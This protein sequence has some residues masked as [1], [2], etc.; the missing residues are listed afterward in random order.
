MFTVI[1]II[2]FNTIFIHKKRFRG[3]VPRDSS[4]NHNF[5]WHIIRGGKQVLI[6]SKT[7]KGNK[8]MSLQIT[9]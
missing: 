5:A 1:L 4:G 3:A 8:D 7:M 6:W 9:H 2:Y